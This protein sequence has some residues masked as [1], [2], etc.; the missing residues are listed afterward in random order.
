MCF[1]VVIVAS[2]LQVSVGMGF[3]M[4]ASPLLALIK[5]EIVPGAILT[6]GLLVAFSGAW[7][8]RKNI[9]FNELRLGFGGRLIGSMMAFVILLFRPTTPIR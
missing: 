2:V 1:G 8:E 5:P 9:S 6:M 3:G 4:L 7:R